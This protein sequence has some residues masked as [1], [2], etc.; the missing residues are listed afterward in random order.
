LKFAILLVMALV[1]LAQSPAFAATTA[2]WSAVGAM[3]AP[4]TAQAQIA[5]EDGRVLVAGGTSNAVPV[6]SAELYNAT[7]QSWTLTGSL[8]TPRSGAA[9]TLLPS[10]KVLVAGGTTTDGSVVAS[11]ELFDPSTESW[12]A[13]GSMAVART[14]FT[15]TLLP[16][17]LVLVTGGC[18]AATCSYLTA[19]AQSELYDPVA[20]TWSSTGSLING[21]FGQTA[22]LLANGKVLVTPFTG[23]NTIG[24]PDLYDPSVGTWS[25][26]GAV[27]EQYPIYAT[28]VQLT[29]GK[30]LMVGGYPASGGSTIG[31]ELYDPATNVWT[32]GPALAYKQ[33]YFSATLLTTGLV[34][35]AGG[36]SHTTTG[37]GKGGGGS[38]TV[39]DATSEIYDPSTNSFSVIGPMTTVRSGDVATLLSD[40]TVLVVGGTSSSAS[41]EIYEPANTVSLAPSSLTFG[42]QLLNQSRPAQLATLTNPASVPLGISA[43]TTSGD[44]AQTSDCP[45][46]LP[47]GQSCTIS[48]TFTPTAAGSRTGSVDIT[49]A[50]VPFSE[51]IAL[52]GTGLAQALA[53]SPA[54]LTLRTV[55]GTSTSGPVTVTDVAPISSS[56]NLAL[57]GN[58]FSQTNDCPTTLAPGQFCTVMVTFAPTTTVSYSGSLTVSGV[59]GRGSQ[60]VP[61][62]GTGTAV[63][64]SVTPS[65]LAFGSLTIGDNQVKTITVLNATAI[66]FRITSIAISGAS[67]RQS[68][69]C[70]ATLAA[71]KKCTI[72]VQFQP[73]VARNYT[74]KVTVTDGS[75]RMYIVT[76]TGAGSTN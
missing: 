22:L 15:A 28:A 33:Q 61:L 17:G 47:A 21:R 25:A 66:S 56:V 8:A 12:S 39:A 57:S 69:N 44:F 51:T 23:T 46:S 20:G 7:T 38:H 30:V 41:T 73:L 63:R 19:L 32:V 72:S 16:S 67:F 52:T 6:A 37:S 2:T 10:G 3:S 36:G 62:S 75:G 49:L 9:A 13:T 14:S 71:G 43:I 27:A 59:L 18:P 40:E 60:S 11:A 58:G 54:G 76:L 42:G 55:A 64:L 24:D 35:I 68:N 31:S 26:A 65:T 70:P 1:V 53:A 50:D 45:A 29:S 4:R 74:G 34:L 5:L 48:V